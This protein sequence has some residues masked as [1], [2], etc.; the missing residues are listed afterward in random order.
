MLYA[1]INSIQSTTII[2]NAHYYLSTFGVQLFCVVQLL[3][4]HCF[5]DTST[6]AGSDKVTIHQEILN[7]S[8]SLLATNTRTTII[9]PQSHHVSVRVAAALHRLST[10]Y[11]DG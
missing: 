10:R 11:H 5:A 2:T 6:A 8:S 3:V 1:T 9:L 4:L 7:S